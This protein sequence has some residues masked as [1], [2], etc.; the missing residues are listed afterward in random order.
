VPSTKG[1]PAAIYHL[2]WH[3]I[4]QH[5]NLQCRH[6]EALKSH[7]GNTLS[8]QP[9]IMTLMWTRYL[10][11]QNIPTTDMLLSASI[12]QVAGT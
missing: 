10:R 1:Q 4:P 8:L 11:T 5:T 6:S 12:H 9:Y 2:T 7:K 3:N